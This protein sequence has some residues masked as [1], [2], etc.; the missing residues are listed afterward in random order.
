MS[1]AATAIGN[2][3]PGI[4]PVVGPAGNFAPLTDVQKLLLCAAMIMGR[5]ELFSVLVLFMPS[6][7]R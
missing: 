3:G 7:Y 6:F 1:A 4:G 5:L 2:V